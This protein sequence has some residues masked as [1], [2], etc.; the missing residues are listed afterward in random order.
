MLLAPFLPT[1]G[2]VLI[3]SKRGVGKT[4]VALGIAYAIAS[5]GNFLTWY[6]PTA[7]KVLYVDGE[8][9]AV[10]MQ[11]RLQKIPTS[12]LKPLENYL[13]FITPDLQ[14]GS[15]PDLSTPEGRAQIEELATGHDL[16]ILDNLSCLIRSGSEN[17]AE[18]WIDVQ[19]WV[20]KLRRAGKSILFIHH[21]GKSG[22]QR[23]T[24][25]KEDVLDTVIYLKQ[26]EDYQSEDGACFEV[27]FEKARHFYGS[28]AA[29]FLVKL[30]QEVDGT[31][32]WSTSQIGINAEVLEI[33]KLMDEG[34]T[35]LEMMEITGL[36]KSQVETLR[37]KAR[38]LIPSNE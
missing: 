8:M 27:Y 3:H 13:Q 36:T 2:L 21:T 29:P 1:Q 19:E 33:A 35:I 9:P 4:H 38:R 15:L 34:R 5:G 32:K 28:D 12:A 10:S 16:I 30:S 7:K 6:A 17:E 20:L 23:G 31:W 25:K 14:T 11:E 37:K 18:S 22:L 26:P 24:S